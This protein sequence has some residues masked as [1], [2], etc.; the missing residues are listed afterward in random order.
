MEECMSEGAKMHSKTALQADS[1]LVICMCT[2][3]EVFDPK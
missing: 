2:I 3:L 1:T